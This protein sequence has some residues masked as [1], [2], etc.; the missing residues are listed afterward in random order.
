M[1]NR[2]AI[3]VVL[4]LLLSINVTNRVAP[5]LVELLQGN[6]VQAN[7]TNDCDYLKSAVDSW[8]NLAVTPQPATFV[9]TQEEIFVLWAQLLPKRCPWQNDDGVITVC[10]ESLEKSRQTACE[11]WQKTASLLGDESITLHSTTG[12][13]LDDVKVDFANEL[14][15]RDGGI[16]LFKKQDMILTNYTVIVFYNENPTIA[17]A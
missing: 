15:I 11:T 9:S 8:L 12:E 17:L 16:R 6:N 7:S 1:N 4:P 10:S 5:N 13:A 14:H 3:V 2:T